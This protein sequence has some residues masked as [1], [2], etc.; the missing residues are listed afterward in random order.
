MRYSVT[1]IAD[2]LDPFSHSIH[3]DTRVLFATRKPYTTN[4]SLAGHLL[5]AKLLDTP[6]EQLN[7]FLIESLDAY[8]DRKT[9][10]FW[11]TSHKDNWVAA[12][13][14]EQPI[15]IDIELIQPRTSSVFSI[16]TDNE[17]QWLGEKT[18]PSFYRGWTAKEAVLKALSLPLADVKEIHIVHRQQ[19]CFLLRYQTTDMSADTIQQDNLLIAIAQRK[20]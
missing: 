2:V 5:V 14:S 20:A 18:W 1:S 4:Q 15:G 12:A 7:S 9:N 19:D 8:Q 11:S 3:P 10:L 17:W 13:V 6:V 16:F